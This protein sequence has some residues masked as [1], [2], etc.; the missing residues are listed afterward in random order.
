[1]VERNNGCIFTPSKEARLTNTKKN[2]TMRLSD[3][4]KAVNCTDAS[5]CKAGIAEIKS[6]LES[7]KKPASYAYGRLAKLQKKLEKFEQSKSNLH[8]IF[9]QAL[10]PFGIK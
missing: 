5:D 6:Y 10:A 3:Y 1:M 2:N 7:K 8:P 9:S 4:T